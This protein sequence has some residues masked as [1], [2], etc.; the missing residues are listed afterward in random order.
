MED[1]MR[2]LLYYKNM[3]P[4]GV[5]RFS[6]SYLIRPESVPDHVLT[7]I[8]LSIMLIKDLEKLGYSINYKEV[9]Y[10]IAIHDLPEKLTSDIIRPVKYHHEELTKEF[11]AAESDMI[12]RSGYPL[13]LID[14]IENAKDDTLEGYIL[15]YVDI[16]QVVLKLYEEVFE[17]GN[18]LIKSE[19]YN[20]KSALQKATE[21]STK[22]DNLR[23]PSS[24]NMES[25]SS[26][27][28][29]IFNS[30]KS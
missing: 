7:C 8:T 27:F 14:D 23:D 24:N 19:Y 29:N 28:N 22:W 6:G 5:N 11:R 26:Y 21:L 30:L 13:F 16:F 25:M 18:L 9:M 15:K 17:L 20:A 3:A 4:I 2:R 10:K 12:R 1:Q